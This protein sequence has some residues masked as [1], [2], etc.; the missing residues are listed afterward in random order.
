MLYLPPVFNMIKAESYLESK[1][2]MQ[3]YLDLLCNSDTISVPSKVNSLLHMYNACQ[4]GN[5]ALVFI[6]LVEL[7]SKEGCFDILEVRAREVVSESSGWDL[8]DAE[9]SDLYLRIAECLDR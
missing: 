8:K 9:R 3:Q 2:L 6:S 5:K 7:C 4:Q 1:K